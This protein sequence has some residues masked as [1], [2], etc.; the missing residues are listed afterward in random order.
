M[1]SRAPWRLGVLLALLLLQLRSAR[2]A[3]HPLA[4]LSAAEMKVG[5]ESVLMRFRSDAALPHEQLLFPLLALH[6][7]PKAFVR[8]WR[9]GQP[10]PRQ[11]EL[12]VMHYPSNRSWLAIVDLASRRVVT[13]LA[14]PPGTEPA[15]SGDEYAAAEALVRAYE[16]WQRAVRARGLD[17]KLVYLDSWAAGEAALPPDVAARAAFGDHTRLLRCLTFARTAQ[18]TAATD[19]QPSA[20]TNAR[21]AQRT[22]AMGAQP[23]AAMNA[24][25]A[26]LP[27]AMGA[28]PSTATITPLPQPSAA[29]DAL[30]PNPYVRPVE[31]LLVTLDLNARKVLDLSDRGVRPVSSDL[32]EAR[33]SEPLRPLTIQQPA[34]S[35]I[36]VHAGLIRWRHWQFYA[37]MH[38]REGL[39]LYDVRFED[40]GHWRSIAYRSSLGEIYVPYGLADPNWAWRRAFDVGEYNAG[41][42]AQR[43]QRGLD[44]PD[45]AQ[46]LDATF[47]ADLGPSAQ[48]PS[49]SSSAP[50]VLAVFERD[51]G[52]LWTRTDPSTR[53]IETRR[54]HE[55][56]ATWNCWIGNYVY[57]FEWIF[58]LDGSIEVR[59]QLGGTTLDRGTDAR[60]EASAPKIGKDDKGAFI[61][62]PN[63][64]HFVSFRLDLDV[65]G[66]KNDVMEMDVAALND[67]TY[68]NAFDSRTD[69]LDRE[70]FRDADPLRSRHWHI[71]SASDTQRL[72]STD[73]V[74]A[75]IGLADR[76]VLRARLL[77]L[78]TRTIR[79]ARAVGHALSRRGAISRRAISE[80]SAER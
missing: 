42:G 27:A 79:R 37:V 10:V 23:S 65:D 44:V 80:S 20:A 55:L 68:K 70:G 75:G 73:R 40:H 57:G 64:Q 18:R 15:I 74:R 66:T 29:D 22:A 59:V 67:P 2:A 76:A 24:R 50:G 43:L 47:F 77:R 72:W 38:P 54:A 6:E 7:P 51:G 17:P 31:G 9:S 48:N 33:S 49:G 62:A 5:F 16:P 11:A 63:H 30:S 3:D 71:E 78:T 61:A 13:L 26:Q 60:R 32:G 19:A 52:A 53:T 45:N 12:Q 14:L 58:K 34:G 25:P 21:P 1:R 8:A 46:L 4:P 35:E 41:L 28:Q 56:V 69:Y 39:V 36:E